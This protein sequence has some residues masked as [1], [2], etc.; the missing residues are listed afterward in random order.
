ML[1]A[2]KEKDQAAMQNHIQNVFQKGLNT[3]DR[4]DD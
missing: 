1:N 2:P 4:V 3:E